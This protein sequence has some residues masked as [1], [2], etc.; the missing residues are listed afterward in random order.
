MEET[1]QIPIPIPE[2]FG[3]LRRYLNGRDNVFSA[4]ESV[5]SK[6]VIGFAAVAS[7]ISESGVFFDNAKARVCSR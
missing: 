7:D 2:I 6:I 4:L 3:D 5:P 1:I